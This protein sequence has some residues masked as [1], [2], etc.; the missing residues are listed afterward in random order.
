[1]RRPLALWGDDAHTGSNTIYSVSLLVI[2]RRLPC[3]CD[4][5]DLGTH[6]HSL[7]YLPLA[8]LSQG[9]EVEMGSFFNMFCFANV[10]YECEFVYDGATIAHDGEFKC[11]ICDITGERQASGIDDDLIG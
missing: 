7:S 2:R 4:M 5:D 9:E 3:T 8:V 1:M 6:G 10:P 11:H